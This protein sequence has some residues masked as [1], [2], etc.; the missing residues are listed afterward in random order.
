MLAV[1]LTVASPIRSQE[2]LHFGINEIDSRSIG[3]GLTGIVDA[4]G[5]LSV[6]RNPA[7]NRSGRALSFKPLF[8]WNG[9]NKWGDVIAIPRQLSGT[10]NGSSSVIPNSLLG[11]TS[12]YFG[13]IVQGKGTTVGYIHSNRDELLFNDGFGLF[14]PQ[15]KF[16]GRHVESDFLFAGY[17]FNITHRSRVGVLLK[18]FRMMD[19]GLRSINATSLRSA[20]DVD[21][22]LDE[23][24]SRVETNVGIDLGALFTMNILRRPITVGVAINNIATDS[25]FGFKP[26]TYV[27]V[28]LALVP[29]SGLLLEANVVNRLENDNNSSDVEFRFGVEYIFSGVRIRSGIA[30]E[31][32]SFGVGIGGEGLSLDYGVI[33][34]DHNSLNGG[35]VK[36]TFQSFQISVS[37]RFY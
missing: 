5:P 27:N 37:G 3:M 9:N 23:E 30:G 11:L 24:G 18:N 14:D 6:L 26:P 12:R 4:Y 2:L 21:D 15:P 33:E 22:F 10:G 7:L 25:L 8:Q 16:Y 28:G 35:I 34:V 32:A 17:T 20:N 29:F 1:S 13:V 19:T 31:N 36:E